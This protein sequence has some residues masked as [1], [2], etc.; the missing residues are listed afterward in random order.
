M[1][2]KDVV[3]DDSEEAKA[4]QGAEKPNVGK[5]RKSLEAAAEP[6]AKKSKKDKKA[7]SE[8]NDTLDKEITE[9]KAKLKKQKAAARKSLEA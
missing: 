9:R 5:K 6:A 7:V 4:L 3:A 2:D 1:A 8:S